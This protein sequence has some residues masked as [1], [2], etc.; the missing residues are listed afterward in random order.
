MKELWKHQITGV[1]KALAQDNFAF[2]FDM[3]TGKTATT[4]N[5]IRHRCQ[6]NGRLMKV[7]IVAPLSVVNNWKK[8]FI[9]FSKI[10]H[11]D[12]LVCDQ[13]G[14]KRLEKFK[15]FVQN[16]HTLTLSKP[17]VI[18]TNY[19]SFQMK[20]FV[21]AL[22]EW[23]PEILVCDESHRLKSHESKRAKIIA[24]FADG[25]KHKIL[26]TGTPILNSAMDIFMQLRVLDGGQSFGK[27]FWAF[28]SQYFEDENA[29]W[30]SRPGHF[31]KFEPRPATF[32]QFNEIIYKKAMRVMKD[33]VLDL[34]PLVREEVEVTLGKEQ[35][36]L[37]NDMRDTF[38]AYIESEE[39]AGK[40]RAV[41]AQLAVT[42][43]LRLQQIISGFAKDEEGKI[44][45]IQEN[46]RIN[47]LQDYLE[48]LVSGHKVIVWSCF[49]E[50]YRLISALLE[51]LKIG[52]AQYHGLISTN[53]RE[54][55]L[56][57]FRKD[58]DC[59]VMVANQGAG[60][61]GINLVEASYSIFYSRNFSL[62]QDLQA[63]A[64]N[65]R[66]GSEIHNKVTRIDLIARGTID[67]VISEVL[68]G[69]LD[70]AE[71]ILN[72]RKRL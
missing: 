52:F 6:Q 47:V 72:M 20:D 63:T 12:I 55:Q 11:R 17:R 27:N 28:R 60:G 45:V 21:A 71:T 57:R 48:Q 32:K 29:A 46:P 16:E 65:H 9:Q 15:L 62:E 61:V 14:K 4:I 43:S 64:R 66:G 44:H 31:P 70:A 23:G 13:S 36:K 51:R 40:P 25:V 54:E 1:Q 56:D 67:D 8:E 18:V 7:L 5:V 39:K 10:D 33:D 50:N 26:L 42:K 53:D 2:F 24:D 49:R 69:K 19:E 37:Y 58:P 34:P 30:A 3:G 22:K 59:R 38:L 68:A 35:Q 41:V